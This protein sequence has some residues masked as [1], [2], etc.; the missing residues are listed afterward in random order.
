MHILCAKSRLMASRKVSGSDGDAIL[1]RDTVLA[2]IA[3]F[4][5][6]ALAIP[7][8]INVGLAAVLRVPLSLLPPIGA[9]LFVLALLVASLVA[10]RA[11]SLFEFTKFAMTGVLNAGVDFGGLNSL[12]LLTGVASG[13]GFIAFKSISVT[14]GVINSYLWNKYWTF[15]AANS[16]GARR[17]LISFMVVTLIAVAVNVAGADVIVNVI[18]APAG[19]SAKLWANVGAISGAGLTLFTNFFGYKF[20]VF[21]K[22]A[23]VALES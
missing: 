1:K 23:V 2:L 14:L 11:P 22:P 16:S 17:E 9:A 20:F 6:G 5:T 8:V 4:L 3:G 21:K 12:M 13:R 15:E 18:G 10:A 19:V 7:I